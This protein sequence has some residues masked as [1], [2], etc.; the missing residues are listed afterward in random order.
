MNIFSLFT[1]FIVFTRGKYLRGTMYRYFWRIFYFCV[2]VLFIHTSEALKECP[3][4]FQKFNIFTIREIF[5]DPE[6]YREYDGQAGYLLFVKKVPRIKSMDR[7]FS[8]VSKALRENFSRLRW[9]QFRG[10]VSEFEDVR[11]WILDEK[12]NLK[13]EYIGMEGYVLFS[14]R[15]Y[16]GDMRKAFINVSAVLDK[17]QFRKLG[18]QEFHGKVSEYKVAWSWILNEEGNIKEEYIG[19]EGY[20]LFSKEYYE[21]DMHKALMNMSAV[22]SKTKFKELKWQIFQGSVSEYETLQSKIL[23]EKGNLRKKYIGM[24]SYALLSKDYE[25]DMKKTF[26]NVSAIL[27]KSKFKELEWRQF[28]DNVSEFESIRFRIIDGRLLWI[29]R[30]VHPVVRSK[31]LDERGA[32]KEEYIGMEG[33]ALFAKRYY[34]GDM[35]RAFQN[36]SAVLSKSEFQRLGWRNFQGSVSEFRSLRSKILKRGMLRIE[37]ISMEGYVLLSEKPYEGD[38]QKTFINVSA[39]LD[40]VQFKKLGWQQFK[41]SVSEYKAVRFWILDEEGN[42]KEEYI[43]M[44][45]CVLL[46]E[47]HYEGNMH[48]AFQNVSAV[49]N[50]LEFKKLGWR[51][52]Q[53]SVS[54]FKSLR[55]DILDEEGNVKEEYISMEGYILLSEKH[56]EG[57]MHKTFQNVSAV[58]G[59]YL[60]MQQ[61]GFTWKHFIGTVSEYENLIRFFKSSSI[62]S[63]QGVEGQKRVAKKI[64]KGNERKTYNNVSV[65][66]EQ[67]LGSRE[68][69]TDLQWFLH[70]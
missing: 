41:G 46:S 51:N 52:F 23:D 36:V 5:S 30:G 70:P 26:I 56:Y 37:Y 21:G 54:E 38:M 17:V 45:G 39:I 58:L 27:S 10:R 32:L 68:A 62:E 34:K 4:A 59:G 64:F 3:E 49:L 18:W 31:I 14:E 61:L 19:M 15:Y 24:E 7:I 25:G 8:R 13:K 33:C 53:G 20:V 43:G 44:E 69:F 16:K 1:V 67:L 2:F 55:F 60:V 9:Q 48:K 12:G 29:L 47:K 11:S 28:R 66:R 35:Q 63:F 65:F 50:K 57:D 6:S 22:L 40:K 42:I